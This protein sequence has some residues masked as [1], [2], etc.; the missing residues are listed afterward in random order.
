MVDVLYTHS[1]NGSLGD[2]FILRLIHLVEVIPES[3]FYD[4]RILRHDTDSAFNERIEAILKNELADALQIVATITLAD[5]YSYKVEGMIALFK[6]IDS[7]WYCCLFVPYRES[8]LKLYDERIPRGYI[9]EEIS[10]RIGHYLKS[11]KIDNC[12]IIGY[13]D[14]RE[15]RELR[16]I[17]FID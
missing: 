12:F 17:R 3:V 8:E 16:E 11:A 6:T 9:V 1:I 5:L 7:E 4:K 10:A 15:P 14:P 13:R 2:D